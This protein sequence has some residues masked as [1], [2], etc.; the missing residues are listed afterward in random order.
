MTMSKRV[1]MSGCDESLFADLRRVVE[2]RGLEIVDASPEE[3]AGEAFETFESNDALVVVGPSEELLA[4]LG[5]SPSSPPLIILGKRAQLPTEGAGFVD[6][7]DPVDA[8]E[9]DAALGR[10]LVFRS[11]Q[12]RER[13]SQARLIR[14]E[15]LAVLGSMV[16]G[17]THEIKTPLAFYQGDAA[18]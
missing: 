5:D 3:S 15:R 10:A 4:T 8:A 18:N 2:R 9:F 1:W 13:D 12:Q 14:S 7:V 16:A 11:L 17:L 6:H